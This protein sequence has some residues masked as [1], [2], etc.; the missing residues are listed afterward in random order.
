[1]LITIVVYG[2]ASMHL[3]RDTNVLTHELREKGLLVADPDR[4]RRV[5]IAVNCPPDWDHVRNN[6]ISAFVILP[7]PIFTNKAKKFE[8]LRACLEIIDK[9]FP[10]APIHI[11]AWESIPHNCVEK[12]IRTTY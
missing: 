5:H 10:S 11:E 7:T 1:M 8:M 3:S 4:T 6:P 9:H 12:R 2:V